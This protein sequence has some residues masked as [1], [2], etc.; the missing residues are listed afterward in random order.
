MTFIQALNLQFPYLLMI[1][2]FYA[3]L[4]TQLLYIHYA[5]IYVS[6]RCYPIC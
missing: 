3:L 4:K 1:L 2:Y 5:M 6:W